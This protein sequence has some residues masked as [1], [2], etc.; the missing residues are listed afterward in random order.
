MRTISERYLAK[1]ATRS[2]LRLWSFPNVFTDEGKRTSSQTG[3]ELADLI[4]VF[5]DQVI[6]FSDKH[7]EYPSHADDRIAWDRWYR[8]A[9]EKSTR[10]LIGAERWIREYPHRL[11]LND[12]CTIPFPSFIP[13]RPN[14]ELHLV[15]V[16]RGSGAACRAYFG[17]EGTPTYVIDTRLRGRAHAEHPFHVGFPAESGRFVHVFDETS[18]DLLMLEL[19]T[20]SDFTS[21]LRMREKFLSGKLS[22]IAPGEEELLALYLENFDDE[23]HCFPSFAGHDAGGL[24]I[25]A[26]RWRDIVSTPRWKNAKALNRI[27]YAWDALIEYLST[28][29]GRTEI[30]GPRFTPMAH[31]EESLRVMAAE[32]RFQRRLLAEAANEVFSRS[33]EAGSRF[34]RVRFPLSGTGATYVFVAFDADTYCSD[35]EYRRA[36][37][38]FLETACL[39]VKRRKPTTTTILGLTC[40]SAASRTSSY[41]VAGL[42]FDGQPLCDDECQ[43]IAAEEEAWRI[44]KSHTE[45]IVTSHELPDVPTPPSQIVRTPRAQYRR[46]QLRSQNRSHGSRK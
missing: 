8:K 46:N 25:E 3:K 30:D 35:D 13:I 7:C 38:S 14:A 5:N 26:G 20:V 36:R 42:F 39:A 18:L 24:M 21:Y 1:I 32:S 44:F 37:R 43:F 2:F 34:M 9:I 33:L 17:N 19:D 27:S 11:F 10:Q 6:I 16:T 31:V 28:Q 12:K 29:L 40:E 22:I 4:V 23:R 45:V 15:A 41:D